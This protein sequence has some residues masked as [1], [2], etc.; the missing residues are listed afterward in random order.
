[1]LRT[2][3]VYCELCLGYM[4]IR[5]IVSHMKEYHEGGKYEENEPSVHSEPADKEGE[6]K[7]HIP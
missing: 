3:N 5:Q 6:D 4:D 2:Y 1:V 7:V